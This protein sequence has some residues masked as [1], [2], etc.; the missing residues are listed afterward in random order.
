MRESN[1]YSEHVGPVIIG[2]VGGSGTRLIAQ[3]LGELGYFMGH[4]LNEADDNLWFTFLFNRAEILTSTEEEFGELLE[5]FIK[6]MTGSGELTG[7]QIDLISRLA[8]T[9]KDANS[10]LRRTLN[11][12]LSR[13]RGRD[14]RSWRERM[15]GSLLTRRPGLQPGSLWGWKEPN[16]H[17]V[18]YRLKG[19]FRDMKYIHVVRNGLDMAHSH[20]QNQLKLWGRHFIGGN[21]SI[22]PYYSLKYWCIVHRRV[23]EIGHSMGANFLF[24]NY[25]HFCSNPEDG[26]SELSGFLELDTAQVPVASLLELVNPP[27]SVGRYRQQGTGIFDVKDVAYVKALGF[28]ID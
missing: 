2:G 6:G 18:L 12:I 26:I 14:P 4:D 13:V 16:S 8:A 25:D 1:Y 27:G 3:C 7:K 24:L 19:C 28:D 11:A 20:N 22:S 21:F 5:I 10:W 23:L 9:D 17:V 15:A